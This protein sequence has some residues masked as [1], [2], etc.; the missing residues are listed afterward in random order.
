MVS[1]G[2]QIRVLCRTSSSLTKLAGLPLE[3]AIG[4]ITDLQRVRLAVKGCEWVIHAA[5][6]LNYWRQDP[7]WQMK[8]NVEGT[9]HVA[10]ACRTEGSKRLVHISSVAAIGIPDNPNRPANEELP[11]RAEESRSSYALSKRRA[12]EAVLSE[13]GRGLDGVIVNP[14]TIFGRHG[15][16]YRGLEMIESIRRRKIVPYFTGGICVV[17]VEDVVEGVLAALDQGESG[18]RY[19]LGGEN[20]TFR[21]L[22]ER[23]AR[24]MRLQRRFVL[25]PP[26][27]SW[28]AAAFLEPVGRL[29]NRRPRLTYAEH[30]Y[31]SRCHFY[32][33]TKAR[34]VLSYAPRDFDAILEDF[35]HFASLDGDRATA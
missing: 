1:E 6:D 22:M 26:V 28:L 13:V 4:D 12:E 30:D 16:Q 14:A 35:L 31:T 24:A 33:S 3:K 20:L 23:T 10:Q 2:H 19:I 11:F 18:Q 21:A 17:H 15:R 7:D 9:R 8:V 34:K 27:V 25:I 5:A 32:D 29:R